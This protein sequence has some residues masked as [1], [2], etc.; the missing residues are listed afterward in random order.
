[1][2]RIEYETFEKEPYEEYEVTLDM[3]PKMKAGAGLSSFAAG[4]PK[5]TRLSDGADVT[6]AVLGAAV[7]SGTRITQTVKGGADGERI[8]I[9]FRALDDQGEKHESGLIME[10]REL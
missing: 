5:G 7:L 9:E 10:I 2:P 6:T 1:M 8:K 4:Y 3:A